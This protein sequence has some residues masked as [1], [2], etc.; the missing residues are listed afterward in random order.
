MAAKPIR[1]ASAFFWLLLGDFFAF[2]FQ[3]CDK[4]LYTFFG[5]APTT[6]D[7]WTFDRSGEMTAFYQVTD[8]LDRIRQAFFIKSI[9]DI[10]R[11]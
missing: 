6:T 4:L 2:F 9:L 1:R 10:S 8:V 11:G 7:A 5:Y 3:R